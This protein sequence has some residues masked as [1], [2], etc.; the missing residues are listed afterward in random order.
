VAR[1]SRLCAV[2]QELGRSGILTADA[3]A[4]IV[5]ALQSYAGGR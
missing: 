1:V 3:E 4:H 5:S 2:P